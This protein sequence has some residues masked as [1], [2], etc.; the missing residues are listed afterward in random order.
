MSS[1]ARASVIGGLVRTP[2]PE[3]APLGALVARGTR[4]PPSTARSTAASIECVREGYLLHY[5]EP[6]LLEPPDP[7]LRC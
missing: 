1:P 6:R 5:G 2:E 7:D 3:P 4:A